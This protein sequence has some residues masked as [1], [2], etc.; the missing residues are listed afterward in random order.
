MQDLDSL[1]GATPRWSQRPAYGSVELATARL[2]WFRF[3]NLDVYPAP[4]S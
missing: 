1:V 2:G 4:A 3:A